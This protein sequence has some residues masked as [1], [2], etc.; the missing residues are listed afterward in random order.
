MKYLKSIIVILLVC[1]TIWGVA[2]QFR[3]AKLEKENASLD[4]RVE[5]LGTYS[6]KL[7]QILKERPMTDE[8]KAITEHNVAILQEQWG[9][10]T[11]AQDLSQSIL[12][13]YRY[14]KLDN[15]KI[16]SLSSKYDTPLKIVLENDTV[17]LTDSDLSYMRTADGDIFYSFVDCILVYLGEYGDGTPVPSPSLLPMGEGGKIS[18]F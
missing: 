1:G 2:N 9:F 5:K 8:E 3:I 6:I 15:A 7:E 14:G 18:D 16:K 10:T 17:L 12:A 11:R 4:Q 13:Y